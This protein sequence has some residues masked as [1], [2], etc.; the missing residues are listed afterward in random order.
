MIKWPF[1]LSKDRHYHH[2]Q[3]H[4]H[5]NLHAMRSVRPVRSQV[6]LRHGSIFMINCIW[7]V[8]ILELSEISPLHA[9]TKEPLTGRSS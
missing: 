4:N 9:K 3:G 7:L 1:S 2:I 8:H 5:T 6:V